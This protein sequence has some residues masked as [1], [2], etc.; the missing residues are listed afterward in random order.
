MHTL[1]VSSLNEQ[2]KT[3]LES[4]FEKVLVEGELSRVTHHGS[5]HIYFSLKDASSSI[6][7][8]MFKGNASRLRFELQE[9]L[10]VIIE[11]AVTLYKPRGEY[12]INCF[13]IQPSGH[14]ALALAY[15][16]LK[17]KLAK[18]GYFSS[19]IKKPLP[20]FPKKIALITSATGAAIADMLRVANSRYRAVE[21][22]IYDVLVQGGS[23]ADMISKALRRADSKGYDI[24][25]IGRGGGSIEDL[26]AFNEEIVADA[27]FRAK[28]PIVSA[29]GH[30]IDWV[31]SDFVSDLR[32]PTPSAAMQMILPD[33]NELY[34]YIDSISA[35]YTQKIVQKIYNSKQELTHLI[36]LYLGHSI[37]KKIAQKIEDIKQLKGAYTQ[38]ISFKMQSFYKEV[39]SIRVRFPHVIDSKINIAQNQV[40]TLQKML[41]SNNPKLKSK[42]GFVQIS[43]DAKV[44]DITSLKVDEVFDLMNDRVIVSAK[45][46]QKRDI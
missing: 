29:V 7:A 14:G 11:G 2:I 3:I 38:T 39:E 6:R 27:I 41:E 40:L 1:S 26:W 34:Q 5:G 8:V 45:V 12:Q 20:K 44:I 17:E 18:A 37:E 15:E 21:I 22:D 25:L 46:L 35:Q 31:I 19:E 24:I 33:E 43:K 23:A 42:K 28:T 16:Q 32:A 9:G 10:K 4:T 13:S 36:N 30:E